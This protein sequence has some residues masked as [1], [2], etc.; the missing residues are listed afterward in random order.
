MLAVDFD[1]FYRQHSFGFHTFGTILLWFLLTLT[2]ST[3]FDDYLKLGA[4]GANLGQIGA[5]PRPAGLPLP[6]F[7]MKLHGK[8]LE[9]RVRA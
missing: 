4:T 8:L 2:N 1:D 5:N 3:S 9:P 6:S 7:A